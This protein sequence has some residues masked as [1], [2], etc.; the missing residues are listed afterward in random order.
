MIVK[1]HKKSLV[2]VDYNNDNLYKSAYL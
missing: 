2:I 1:Y